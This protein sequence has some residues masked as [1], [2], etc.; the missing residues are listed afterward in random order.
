MMTERFIREVI[1]ERRPALGVLWLGDPDATQHNHP[2]GSV[3]HLEALRQS[4]SRAREVI[5]AVATRRAAGEDILLIVGSDHGHQTVTGVIDVAQDL[6]AA[7]LKEAEDSRDVVVASNGTSA[8]IYVDPA[9]GDRV[10][11]IHAHLDRVDWADR[12]GSAETLHSMGQA[13]HQ[14][15]A[16][17]VSMR[18][19]DEP[20]GQGIRGTSL[21]AKPNAGKADRLGCGQHG[22]LGSYEQMP[23]LM[24]SGTGFVS[25]AVRQA[26]AKVVDLAPTILTHLGKPAD[27][28]DGVALQQVRA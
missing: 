2:L 5:E 1:F 8:L 18:S 11:A 23:F 15:L 4:D 7:G 14:G 28:M 6:I 20:N 24:I 12:F 19:S 16:F 9:C 25:G 21:V 17:A 26:P 3:A 13:P 10:P 22:G 27:G